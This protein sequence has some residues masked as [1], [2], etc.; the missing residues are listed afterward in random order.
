[1]YSKVQ[2]KLRTLCVDRVQGTKN[3]ATRE[4][5][6][7][8]MKLVR[9]KHQ[10]KSVAHIYNIK[11]IPDN[12]KYYARAIEYQNNK[13]LQKNKQGGI[14]CL[15]SN[16]SDLTAAQLWHTY[17]MLTE[18]ESAFRSLKSEL[19]IHPVSNSIESFKSAFNRGV[20]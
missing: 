19:G 3:N 1:M 13:E 17:A 12:K 16:R 20:A 18:I 9:L 11:I 15:S 4:Y 7:V 10:Y 2:G 8:A 6:K 14:Y 5:D